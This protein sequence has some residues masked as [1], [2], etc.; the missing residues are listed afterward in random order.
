MYKIVITRSLCGHFYWSLRNSM[1]RNL[2]ESNMM[3]SKDMC[4]KTIKPIAIK[5]KAKVIF[6]DLEQDWE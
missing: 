3:A 2:A 5:L 4:F 1:G 6:I